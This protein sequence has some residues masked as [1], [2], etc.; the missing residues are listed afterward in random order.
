MNLAKKKIILETMKP[1]G[2]NFLKKIKVHLL[3]GTKGFL[4]ETNLNF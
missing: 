3:I 4:I 2:K 1:Y